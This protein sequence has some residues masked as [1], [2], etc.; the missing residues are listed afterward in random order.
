VTD[1][2]S[3]R[4]IE[5]THRDQWIFILKSCEI[6]ENFDFFPQKLTKLFQFTL[7]KKTHFPKLFKKGR[8]VSQKNH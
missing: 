6:K 7:E 8:K 5:T 1:E 4:K 3:Q 2:K